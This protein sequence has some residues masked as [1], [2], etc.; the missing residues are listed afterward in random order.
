MPFPSLT[1]LNLYRLTLGASEF[2]RAITAL[3]KR[4]EREGH[5]GVLGYRFFVNGHEKTARAVVDY[6]DANA[7][8]GHHD[9]AMAWPEMKA[10]HSV[11]SLTDVTFLGDLTPEI[12]D[13]IDRSSLKA[14]VHS[15]NRFAAG[16]V[17]S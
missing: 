4:V 14:R 13:W 10:L 9:I 8:I 15:G 17:R 11:A 2:T 6:R 12:Q 1:I 5:P 16:F 7:W 3:S